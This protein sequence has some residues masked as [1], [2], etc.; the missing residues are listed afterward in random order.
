VGRFV[1]ADAGAVV[2]YSQLAGGPPPAL[3]QTTKL[4][5]EVLFLEA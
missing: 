1:C 5:K 3:L 2:V 4:K